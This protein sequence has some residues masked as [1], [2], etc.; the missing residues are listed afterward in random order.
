MSITWYAPGDF[1]ISA[2]GRIDVLAGSSDRD[3]ETVGSGTGS[4]SQ[5]DDFPQTDCG[6]I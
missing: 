4:H 1:A 3:W 5:V 6:G 2:V